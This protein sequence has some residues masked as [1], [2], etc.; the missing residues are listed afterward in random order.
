MR[1]SFADMVQSTTYCTAYI[2]NIFSKI[3]R[4]NSNNRLYYNIYNI[5][6]TICTYCTYN[7][8][9]ISILDESNSIYS[10][11]SKISKIYVYTHKMSVQMVR[12]VQNSV[13]TLFLIQFS[14]V[15]YWNTVISEV[16]S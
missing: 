13:S 5:Y 6:Y 14:L 8:Y 15:H 16:Q 10:N 4:K 7:N 11:I 3:E 12:L 2:Q 1:Y 9:N